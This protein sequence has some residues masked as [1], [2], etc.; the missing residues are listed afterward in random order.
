MVKSLSP[1]SRQNNDQIHVKSF[2]VVDNS[3]TFQAQKNLVTVPTEFQ[4]RHDTPVFHFEKFANGTLAASKARQ[5]DEWIQNRIDTTYRKNSRASNWSTNG[6]GTVSDNSTNLWS[7]N[8][9]RN[10]VDVA[11]KLASSAQINHDYPLLKHVPKAIR[12]FVIAQALRKT[13]RINAWSIVPVQDGQTNDQSINQV[14]YTT[15]TIDASNLLVRIAQQI[16]DQCAVALQ[17]SAKIYNVAQGSTTSGWSFAASASH[18]LSSNS[19]STNGIVDYSGSQN[20]SR[21]NSNVSMLVSASSF[22][23]KNESYNLDFETCGY[24][25]S[26]R[27]DKASQQSS[28]KLL[29]NQDSETLNC[30]AVG[31]SFSKGVAEGF[32]TAPI[33]YQQSMENGPP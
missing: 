16:T 1:R 12:G 29:Q 17:S 7:H 28:K 26:S 31:Q 24:S 32:G 10:T 2:R 13:D 23:N 4:V 20:Y 18:G 8:D 11:L 19:L 15:L 5:M 22:A 14:S 27:F 9:S 33:W 6:F 25:S 30:R 21:S 3:T